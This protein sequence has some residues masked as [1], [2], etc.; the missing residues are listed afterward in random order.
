MSDEIMNLNELL[1]A[2]LKLCE[3]RMHERSRPMIGPDGRLFYAKERTLIRRML[4][5]PKG[6]TR[7]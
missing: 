5:L 3:E 1:R 2:A 6:E 4:R 7:P